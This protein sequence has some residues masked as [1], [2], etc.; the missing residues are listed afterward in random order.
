MLGAVLL[1]P[2]SLLSGDGLI[3]LH[4][5]QH[6]PRYPI[7]CSK[8]LAKPES[9][10]FSKETGTI[11]NLVSPSLAKDAK[12]QTSDTHYQRVPKMGSWIPKTV[13][14]GS[15]V[16]ESLWGVWF[17]TLWGQGKFVET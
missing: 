14:R 13:T 6:P 17:R 16:A 3:P 4:L 9:P 8:Q 1:N 15:Y 10:R 7:L 5:P 11:N 12:E 2:T